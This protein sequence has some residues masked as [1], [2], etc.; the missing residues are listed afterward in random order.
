[1]VTGFLALLELDKCKQVD[2]K[3]DRLFGEIEIKYRE[4]KEEI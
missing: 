3:Q 2:L 1:M 4:N